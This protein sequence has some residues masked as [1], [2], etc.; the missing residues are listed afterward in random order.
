MLWWSIL[1]AN[2]SNNKKLAV[3]GNSFST[4]WAGF[5]ML[6]AFLACN[7]TAPLP[8]TGQNRHFSPATGSH[9]VHVTFK[10]CTLKL[11]N[12]TSFPLKPDYLAGGLVSWDQSPTLPN[13]NLWFFFITHVWSGT[14]EQMWHTPQNLQPLEKVNHMVVLKYLNWKHYHHSFS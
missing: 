11:A 6:W 4:V 9:I 10:V 2:L 3:T 7:P 5:C 14:R 12:T 13:I 8:S 1:W